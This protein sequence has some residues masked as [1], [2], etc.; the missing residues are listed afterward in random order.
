M[1]TI[2]LDARAFGALKDDFA[3]AETHLL[4]VLF[5]GVA[6]RHSSGIREHRLKVARDGEEYSE[7]EDKHV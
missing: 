1:S 7:V 5:G 6:L 4:N 2:W 3:F